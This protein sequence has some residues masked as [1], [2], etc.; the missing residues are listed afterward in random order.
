MLQQTERSVGK[1]A[2]EN[3]LWDVFKDEFL[4]VTNNIHRATHD[5]YYDDV[6]AWGETDEDE[7]NWEPHVDQDGVHVCTEEI[8]DVIDR[9]FWM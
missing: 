9:I 3:V 6:L 8:C 2:V 4:P 7:D 1:H 5:I